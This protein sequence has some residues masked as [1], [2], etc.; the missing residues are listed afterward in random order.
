MVLGL[1]FA[2]FDFTKLVLFFSIIGIVLYKLF[3][4]V[5]NK[6]IDKYELSWVKS[7][8]ILNFIVTFLLLEFIYV[9]FFYYGLVNSAIFDVELNPT[10]WDSLLMIFSE[11]IRVIIASIIISMIL[12]IIEFFSSMAISYQKEKNYAKI[13]KQFVGIFFGIAIILFIGLFFF[14]WVPLGLFIYIFY[15]G[16]N[17]L[18]V[19]LLIPTHILSMVGAIL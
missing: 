11:M 19:F 9:Y 13:I 16:I 10:L 2:I 7:I 17:P 5:L 4:P 18:P 12:L 3:T 1:F 14:D 6:I 15:G 8:F